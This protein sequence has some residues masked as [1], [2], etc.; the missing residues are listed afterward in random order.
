MIMIIV[1]SAETNHTEWE[2]GKWFEGIEPH[3]NTVI[4]GEVGLLGSFV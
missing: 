4:Q 3:K 1:G 2:G